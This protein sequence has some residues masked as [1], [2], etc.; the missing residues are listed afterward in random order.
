MVYSYR[1]MSKV[2]FSFSFADI[3]Q[4]LI[5]IVVGA[6]VVVGLLT[7]RLGTLNP[8]FTQ[9]ELD[10]RASSSS[11]Q[12]II[13]NPLYLVQ[14]TSQLALIKLNHKG[15]VAMRLPSILMGFAAVWAM[16]IILGNWHTKRMAILGTLLFATSSW[17]LHTARLAASDVNYVLPLILIAGGIWLHQNKFAPVAVP[18]TIFTAV[19]LLYVPAMVLLLVPVVLW[20]RR[21]LKKAIGQLPASWQALITMAAIVGLVPLVWSFVQSP[22]LSLTWLGLPSEW[23]SSALVYLHNIADIV[24]QIFIH[25]QINPVYG[26]GRLPFLDIFTGAMVALGM[27]AYLFRLKLDRTKLLVGISL[28][29]ILLVALDGPVSISF[30]LPFVYVLAAAGMTLLLQQWFTVFPRN[31]FARALAVCI[32]TTAV[33]ASSYYHLNHYF[34]AWPNIPETKQAFSHNP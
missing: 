30:L 7:Y 21:T 24:L 12:K 26:I 28:I 25:G 14:K 33:L 27:F 3:W 5:L 2:R 13:E 18:L 4:T 31:P 22:R 8:G 29:G 19:A 10:Q 15:P 32:I 20:Q 9:A 11:V 6:L 1:I 16:F 17:F 23:P 34:V